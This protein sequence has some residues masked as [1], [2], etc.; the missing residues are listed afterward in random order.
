M[1]G[2]AQQIREA[3]AH[4]D[5]CLMPDAGNPQIRNYGRFPQKAEWLVNETMPDLL[6]TFS[7]PYCRFGSHEGATSHFGYWMDR[8]AVED[9]PT[10]ESGVEHPRQE[11]DYKTVND[12]GNIEIYN[13]RGKS[14][15]GFV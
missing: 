14:I 8:E 9:L 1:Q 12:H 3:L 7:P 2:L 15:C 13:Y 5:A 11:G 6:D 10:L 4:A